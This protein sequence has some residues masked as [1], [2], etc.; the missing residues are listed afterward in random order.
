ML[1]IFISFLVFFFYFCELCII[2]FA[3]FLLLCL[4]LIIDPSI[5]LNSAHILVTYFANILK[6]L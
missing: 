4:L 2:A 3:N 1:L 5:N 6:G